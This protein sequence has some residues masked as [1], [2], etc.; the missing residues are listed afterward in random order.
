MYAKAREFQRKAPRQARARATVEVLLEATAQ[1][2]VERGYAGLTTTRI[3]ERAGVSVGTL[4]Q[5]FEGKAE[6][7]R[8]VHQRQ[9]A[10]AF[11]ALAHKALSTEALAIAERIEQMLR[12]LLEV[13]SARPSLSMA[14]HA[15]MLELDGPAYLERTISQTQSLVGSVLENHADD[16]RGV[17]LDLAAFVLTNAVDGVIEAAIATDRLADPH[18]I[19]ALTRLV[20]GYLDGA[21]AKLRV[22]GSNATSPG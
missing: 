8:T 4:Y 2:L 10:R 20:L 13:K 21:S 19:E 6:L 18:L 16:L 7:V 11:D 5:Y 3:A 9:V 22:S 15:T 14:L 12:A 1:V 17:D